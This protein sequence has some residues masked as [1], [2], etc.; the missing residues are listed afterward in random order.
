MATALHAQASRR[1]PPLRSVSRHPCPQ[2]QCCRHQAQREIRASRT[3]DMI[4]AEVVCQGRR[5]GRV[6]SCRP[7]H[8]S[9][10]HH[11]SHERRR[12]R[13][14]LA[15]CATSQPRAPPRPRS[16]RRQGR[17]RC[18]PSGWLLSAKPSRLPDLTLATSTPTQ[19]R[20]VLLPPPGPLWRRPDRWQQGKWW[21]GGQ[22]SK[23][24]IQKQRHHQG[25]KV[26]RLRSTCHLETAGG[27]MAALSQ[28]HLHQRPPRPV[29]CSACR[30]HSRAASI[31][32]RAGHRLRRTRLHAG[33]LRTSRP[34]GVGG[35]GARAERS[36]S[37]R[38]ATMAL[39]G[40]QGRAGSPTESRRGR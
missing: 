18:P 36:S 25:G 4:T 22:A 23:T 28:R 6:R 14:S 26:R 19:Y 38:S 13:P 12:W 3:P 20:I 39:E 8:R 37:R 10:C 5:R 2:L 21:R 9:R 29:L 32:M 16:G 1:L 17:P 30:C 31:R 11:R 27:G 40:R 7:P 33:H 24:T 35:R 15:E 34:Q